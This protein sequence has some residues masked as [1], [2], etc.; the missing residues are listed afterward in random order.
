MIQ[1]TSRLSLDK[2]GIY[3]SALENSGQ[4]RGL[5]VEMLNG[6]GLGLT[7]SCLAVS[8]TFPDSA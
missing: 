3:E 6:I 5:L 4:N 8:I 1:I 7:A 2:N